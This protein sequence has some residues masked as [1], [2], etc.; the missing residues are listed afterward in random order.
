MLS[1]QGKTTLVAYII[2]MISFFIPLKNDKSFT[3]KLALGVILLIPIS[4]SIYTINCLVTGSKGK[5]GFGCNIMAWMN[6][7]SIFVTAVLIILMQ[8]SNKDNKLLNNENVE[9]FAS[10]P[11]MI[12][13]NPVGNGK[14]FTCEDNG[15]ECQKFEDD[16]YQDL[17]NT[18][19]VCPENFTGSTFPCRVIDRGEVAE[20][21]AVEAETAATAAATEANAKPLLVEAV[22]QAANTAETAAG[23]AEAE[24][25]AATRDLD[26]FRTYR[27]E[28]GKIQD[29][30]IILIKLEIAADKA[31]PAA[32]RA[33]QAVARARQA[34]AQARQLAD[35][36]Q[37]TPQKEAEWG[38]AFG[39]DFRLMDINKGFCDNL[40]GSH[41]S[42]LG[43]W[44]GHKNLNA[45]NNPESCAKSCRENDDCKF[46]AY[47][48]EQHCILYNKDTGYCSRTQRE[49]NN[50]EEYNKYLNGNTNTH[51]DNFSDENIYLYNNEGY[52]NDPSTRD[53]EIEKQKEIERSAKNQIAGSSHKDIIDKMVTWNGSGLTLD[54][55]D[56]PQK[57]RQQKLEE[58][59]A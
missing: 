58:A 35:A 51:E 23:V 10:R 28:G 40:H 11:E 30:K 9:G 6:S 33:R 25:V 27:I 49:G 53:E 31:N 14:I 45:V 17:V 29:D 54:N 13:F 59:Q 38:S 43:G 1:F 57:F 47:T 50:L 2:L 19:A 48:P 39:S 44:T 7:I 16:T 24:A 32:A 12:Y 56:A 15:N 41:S 42:Y 4:L 8:I 21:A 18:L 20:T 22:E 5:F 34:V 52:Y 3:K 26:G 37:T 36:E 55:Y 46:V